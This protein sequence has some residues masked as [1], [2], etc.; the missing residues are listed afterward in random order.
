MILEKTGPSVVKVDEPEWLEAQKY[1]SRTWQVN[2]KRNGFP[3]LVYKYIKALKNPKLFLQYLKHHDF[4]C[5]N[6]WNYWWLEKFE[7]F[8]ALPKQVE[9]SL[10]VGSGPYSNTRIISQIVKIK[11]IHCTDPLMDEYKSFKLNWVSE[12]AKKGRI[13]AT[14]GKAE[15]IEYPDNFFDMV[16]CI[17]V[18]D[19]VQDARACLS[20]I[21]RVLKP[22]GYFIFGQDLTDEAD[23]AKNPALDGH[24]I[25][26]GAD[27]LGTIL[28]PKYT[29][30][31]KKIL[32]RHESRS[33]K[34]QC[35]TYIFIGKKN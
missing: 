30:V 10:E 13:T 7:Y 27:L 33:P 26:L 12:M 16:T 5:G 31:L 29:P 35:G 9:R 21:H 23:M 11:D 25:R 32:P 4:Y 15:Q 19:H 24:P 34:G 22:G 20:E 3:K 14:K 17:N 8:K 1:E 18:L 6:D 28:D 2:N